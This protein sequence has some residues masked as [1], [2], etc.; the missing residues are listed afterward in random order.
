MG[1]TENYQQQQLKITGEN[2]AQVLNYS[3][4]SEEEFYGE[5]PGEGIPPGREGMRKDERE[6][7]LQQAKH[8]AEIQS[9]QD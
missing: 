3:R 5:E 9:T 4:T 7:A 2:E 1:L 8:Q 6:V